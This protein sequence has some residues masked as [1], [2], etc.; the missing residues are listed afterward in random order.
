MKARGSKSKVI[1]GYRVSLRLAWATRTCQ[2]KEREGRKEGERDGGRGKGRERK[3]GA[4]S[5]DL[6]FLGRR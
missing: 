3:E 2:K 1:L 4:R 5:I 6:V